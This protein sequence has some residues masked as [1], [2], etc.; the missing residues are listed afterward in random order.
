MD[1]G[2]VVAKMKNVQQFVFTKA[3]EALEKKQT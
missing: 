1:P 2:Q 3:K